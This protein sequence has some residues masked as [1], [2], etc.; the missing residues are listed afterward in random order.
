MDGRIYFGLLGAATARGI[1]QRLP[2][3][4]Y[5]TCLPYSTI[6]AYHIVAKVEGDDVEERERNCEQAEQDVTDSKVGDENVSR[7]QHV[8]GR[9]F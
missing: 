6:R 7:C 1:V 8:L 2:Y 9:L 3:F 4:T 5:F